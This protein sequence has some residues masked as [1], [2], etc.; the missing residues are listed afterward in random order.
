MSNIAAIRA[1]DRYAELKEMGKTDS[2][3]VAELTGNA[4]GDT[5][6]EPEAKPKAKATAKTTAKPKTVKPKTTVGK[7]KS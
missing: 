2:E 1:S 6:V 7:L 5:P 4:V 3:I